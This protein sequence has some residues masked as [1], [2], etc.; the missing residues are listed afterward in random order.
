MLSPARFLQGIRLSLGLRNARVA[1]LT[2][3]CSQVMNGYKTWCLSATALTSEAKGLSGSTKKIVALYTV[4]LQC[5]NLPKSTNGISKFSGKH[6]G[7]LWDNLQWT[8]IL[9]ERRRNSASC[10]NLGEVRIGS[11]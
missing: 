6:N 9:S 7:L 5:H 2:R 10:L 11:N 1:A 3:A 8:G 4:L